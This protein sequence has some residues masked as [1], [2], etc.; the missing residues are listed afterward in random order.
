[1]KFLLMS[2]IALSIL[3]SCDSRTPCTLDNPYENELYTISN[4]YPESF[5]VTEDPYAPVKFVVGAGNNFKKNNFTLTGVWLCIEVALTFDSDIDT[6]QYQRTVYSRSFDYDENAYGTQSDNSGGC[7]PHYP[8]GYTYLISK[9]A[10]FESGVISL[11]TFLCTTEDI[12]ID[13]DQKVIIPNS[14]A[15]VSVAYSINENVVSF[16]QNKEFSFSA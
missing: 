6:V 5:D 3:T 1:M 8:V 14:T 7:L 16:E 13:T 4:Y 12:T 15:T 10:F 2:I 9:N 11:E